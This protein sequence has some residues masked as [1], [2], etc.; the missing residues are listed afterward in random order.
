MKREDVEKIVRAGVALLDVFG[1]AESLH[2]SR[3]DD[4]RAPYVAVR[5]RNDADLH[6]LAGELGAHVHRHDFSDESGPRLFHLS[7]VVDIGPV[8]TRV[9]M[10]G[11]NHEEPRAQPSDPGALADAIAKVNA[12]TGGQL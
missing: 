3:R 1:A 2:I 7:A 12:A 10:S 11:P 6:A 9:F 4:S 5:F 8:P